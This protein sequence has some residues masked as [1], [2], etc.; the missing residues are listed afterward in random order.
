MDACLD[1]PKQD[2]IVYKAEGEY[3]L[4]KGENHETNVNENYCS[5]NK[6]ALHRN[7]FCLLF[8]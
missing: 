2:I 8:E 6:H 4:V 1:F 5:N 3:K 7:S